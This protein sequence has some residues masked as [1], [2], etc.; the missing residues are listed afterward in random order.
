MA[1]TV[2]DEQANFEAYKNNIAANG[3]RNG[4]SLHRVISKGA[5]QTH[6]VQP[7]AF[8]LTF[9]QQ[10]TFTSGVA[11]SSGQLQDGGYPIVSVGVYKWQTDAR[12]FYRGAYLWVGV[13]AAPTG[14][15]SDNTLLGAESAE[16]MAIILSSLEL[17]HHL[18]FEGM[19]IRDVDVDQ[20]NADI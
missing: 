6:I 19:A 9:V 16:I 17:E 8:Q 5:G 18:C 15:S 14:V 7:L 13:T 2:W 11:L 4:R 12:G 3:A 20:L 10:P 1:L